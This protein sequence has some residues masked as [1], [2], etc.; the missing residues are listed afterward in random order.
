M[1]GRVLASLRPAQAGLRPQMM[2]STQ[3]RAAVNGARDLHSSVPTQK[4]Q[5][6]ASSIDSL[7]HKGKDGV[8]FAVTQLDN[9]VNW[10]RK[11]SIWPMTFGLGTF[12]LFAYT[13][14]L[15]PSISC[16][17]DPSQVRRVYSRVQSTL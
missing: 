3:A 15:G 11:G 2:A 12:S 4:D 8:E 6:G 13:N 7:L 10:A 14:S 16:F 17:V 9:V 1:L 5:G